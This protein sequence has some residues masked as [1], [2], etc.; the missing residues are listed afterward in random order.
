MWNL[1]DEIMKYQFS[2]CSVKTGSSNE[3]RRIQDT[4]KYSCNVFA[5][6]DLLDDLPEDRSTLIN[7]LYS[8]QYVDEEE[9]IGGFLGGF[10]IGRDAN[11]V[12]LKFI[13]FTH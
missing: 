7:W 9:S 12:Y 13:H 5:G 4:Y 1:E 6:L 2:Y 10:I 8:M 11:E 3:S